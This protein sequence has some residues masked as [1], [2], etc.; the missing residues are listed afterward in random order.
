MTS[1]SDPDDRDHAP[2]DAGRPLAA[3]KLPP[4]LLQRLIEHYRTPPDSSVLVPP[5][6]GHDAAA[7]AVGD[8]TLVVK[9]DPITFA[10]ESAASYLVAINANDVACLGAQPRWL[11]VV[12]LLPEGRAT[13]SDVEAMFAE[14]QA[15]CLPLGI[16][17]I[18]GHTEVTL[19]LER[20]ILV[21]T[22]IGSVE[23]D[24][25]L[26][27]GGAKVGDA[28]LLTK[29]VGIEGTALLAREKGDELLPVLGPDRLYQAAKLLHRPGI[30]VV[31]DAAAVQRVPGVHAL[32]DP[33]E[34]GVA[35]GVRE[36]ALAAGVGAELLAEALPLLPET[37]LICEHFRIDPLGLLAS[38]SL[39]VAIDP[40]HVDEAVA[41]ARQEGI[42]I[43]QVG[44]ILPPEDGL[45]LVPTR[46]ARPQPLPRFDA[47]EVTRVL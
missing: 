36:L 44:R 13:E 8:Q 37:R 24:R 34:G 45:V 26:Q 15:A 14:L 5:G 4:E 32:H 7:I 3:G 38:G 25:L 22:L 41:A 40:H 9:S 35:M 1:H 23:R 11:T 31:R 39:L 12:G 19:G 20:P 6:I 46:G 21:G 42:P 18:G 2:S 30:S 43:A 29:A 10:T 16:S 28:I 17:V 47:D 27:P 33:T